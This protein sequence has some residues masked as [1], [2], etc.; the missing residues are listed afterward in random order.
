MSVL[1]YSV[2]SFFFDLFLDFF[3]SL[4]EFALLILD[5]KGVIPARNVCEIFE[6]FATE[7]SM[8]V[9]SQCLM[10]EPSPIEL[11]PGSIYPV[12]LDLDMGRLYTLLFLKDP[13]KRFLRLSMSLP[14]I[15]VAGCAK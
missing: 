8:F 11:L 7:K 12:R 4:A 1:T 9:E 10:F 15:I 3:A 13:P 5:I 2:K 6:A 14:S